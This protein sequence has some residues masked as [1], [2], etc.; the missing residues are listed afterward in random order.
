MFGKASF[1]RTKYNLTAPYL[2]LYVNMRA[3]FD[4]DFPRLLALVD[5]G[6]AV[7]SAE[8]STD[9]DLL[10]I[11]VPIDGVDLAAEFNVE[12]VLK[13]MV[14]L[15]DV[16]IN[17]VTDVVAPSLKND[18]TEEFSLENVLLAPGDTMI[19]D[20]DKLE[21]QVNDENLLESWVSG[22]VFFQLKPGTNIIQ[23]Y[24]KPTNCQLTITVFWAD[25]YL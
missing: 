22:G 23:F 18:E 9:S 3:N 2:S 13:A 4:T 14:P 5:I 15:G 8:Y 10:Y 25:R 7:L 20:T 19:I 12:A 24:T 17:V 11:K 21:I 6:E 16:E 1:N